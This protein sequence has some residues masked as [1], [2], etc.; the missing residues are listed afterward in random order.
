[1]IGAGITVE[2]ILMRRSDE[3]SVVAHNELPIIA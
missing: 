3:R 2:P 1:M